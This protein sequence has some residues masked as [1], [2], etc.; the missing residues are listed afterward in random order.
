[1]YTENELVDVIIPIIQAYP[2]KRAALFGSYARNEQTASS[3]V[4]LLFDLGVNENYPTIDYI[5][6][7]LTLIENK[8]KLRVD[9][10]TLRSLR[11]AP[12]EK[13]KKT[14]EQE[15]RWFYEV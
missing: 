15:S 7:L 8:I 3:D 14:V 9:Y 6:D 13:F 2:V 11:S 10:L 12:S 5:Y 1:M 4:D